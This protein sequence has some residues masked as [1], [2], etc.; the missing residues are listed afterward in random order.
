M[1]AAA[2][3]A[4]CGLDVRVLTAAASLEKV[5]T[6]PPQVL[7]INTGTRHAAER[8]AADVVSVLVGKLARLKPGVLVKKI[9]STLRGHVVV[10]TIAAMEAS[11]YREVVFCGSQSGTF[12]GRRRSLYQ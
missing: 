7:S 1:D 11:G 10:E 8:V 12:S 6:D 2:P 4:R 5:R 3:F 9:D